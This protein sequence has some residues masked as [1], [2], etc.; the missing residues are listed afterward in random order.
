MSNEEDLESILT[1]TGYLYRHKSQEVRDAAN[2]LYSI[3]C[4][5]LDDHQP[6]HRGFT[7]PGLGYRSFAG[8]G[9]QSLTKLITGLNVALKSTRV[10]LKPK[11]PW[12]KILNSIHFSLEEIMEL[13][14]VTGA[15]GGL[16]MQERLTAYIPYMLNKVRKTSEWRRSRFA[17]MTWRDISISLANRDDSLELILLQLSSRLDYDAEIL[18]KWIQLGSN[19]SAKDSYIALCVKNRD[20]DNLFR[21]VFRDEIHLEFIAVNDNL[22]TCAYVL[23]F[24]T[25]RRDWFKALDTG[26]Y[27]LTEKADRWFSSQGS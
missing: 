14:R 13:R 18:K 8:A 9:E 23:A 26:Y 7:A 4:I 22:E 16:V 6:S 2:P 24:K 12:S 20:I 21:R 1:I 5:I 11:G 15:L 25:F 19:L 10:L 3:V 27:E 17:K